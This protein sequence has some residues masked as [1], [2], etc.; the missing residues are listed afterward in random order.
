MSGAPAAGPTNREGRR[1]LAARFE[2]LRTAFP[3]RPLEVRPPG[4]GLRNLLSDVMLPLF[5]LLGVLVAVGRDLPLLLTDIPL[6][7]SGDAQVMSEAYLGPN[8]QCRLWAGAAWSCGL[9]LR[10]RPPG[11]LWQER[12]VGYTQVFAAPGPLPDL[13]IIGRPEAPHWLTTDHALGHVGNRVITFAFVAGTGFY[14]AWR[15]LRD[16]LA[17]RA[18]IRRTRR[19]LSGK[20][21][22]PV[23]LR[24]VRRGTG[25]RAVEELH[26]EPEGPAVP[27]SDRRRSAL[28][29]V[30]PAGEGPPVIVLG[31]TAAGT[32]AV[33]PIDRALRWVVLTA[34]ESA[35][36]TEA[37]GLP[38]SG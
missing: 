2:A 6:A 12:S 16:S 23:L 28:F 4:L 29:P 30:W 25:R 34:E 11:G 7:L 14:F 26:L 5:P 13:R 21:L 15:L 18:A 8:S 37:A 3:T 20:A 19:A 27:R 31:V 24:V 9:D 10:A 17:Q 32:D 35:R 38:P 33:M 1:A 22:Q 36:L